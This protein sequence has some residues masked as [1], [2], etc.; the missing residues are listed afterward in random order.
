VIVNVF[1]I[2]LFKFASEN[3]MYLINKEELSGTALWIKD[4]FEEI[5]IWFSVACIIISMLFILRLYLKRQK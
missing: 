2:I 4:H 5:F 1:I 3:T